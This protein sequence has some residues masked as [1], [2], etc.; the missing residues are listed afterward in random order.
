VVVGSICSGHGF[1]FGPLAG[2][3]LAGLVMDGATGVPEF[4]RHR[5]VF[6]VPAGPGARAPAH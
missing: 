6:A 1:K 4:E 2:R 3:L 5:E